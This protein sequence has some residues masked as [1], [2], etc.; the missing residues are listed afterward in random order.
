MQDVYRDWL[1]I[2]DL[3]HDSH[4]DDADFYPSLAGHAGLTTGEPVLELACGTGRLLAPL[5]AAGYTAVGIDREEAALARASRRLAGWQEQVLLVQADMRD[6]DLGQRFRFAF[7]G[8]NAFLHL[9]DADEQLACLRCTRRH[10]HAGGRL[11]IAMQNPLSFRGGPDGDLLRHRFTLPHPET[12]ETVMQ[13]GREE[14][15]EAA[16]TVTVALMTDVIGSSGAVTRR[17]ASLTL[18][19]V[20][21]FELE[22]L[23]RAASFL[24]EGCY[25]T[26]DLDPY[27]STSPSLIV[28]ARAV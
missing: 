8:L 9:R 11:A 10:L 26:H 23:L 28:L 20:F 4:T 15:D 16:Q 19:L 5:L 13:F 22:A 3:H 2:Y 21:R 27:V 18:R 25:G 7:A 12:G 24:P 14:V 1:D 6:Y 17:L